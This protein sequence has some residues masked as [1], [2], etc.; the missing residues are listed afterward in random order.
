MNI[1][2]YI[3]AGATLGWFAYTRMHFNR[4][5]SKLVSILIGTGGGFLGGQVFA[6]MVASAATIQGDF[7]MRS[8]IIA[9]LGAA[10]CLIIASEVHDRFGV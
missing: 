7:S 4:D 2:L 5:R 3:L 1:A 10:I 8:L 9:G 6:P